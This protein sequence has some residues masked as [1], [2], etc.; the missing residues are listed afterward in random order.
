[1][2]Q[3]VTA[4]VLAASIVLSAVPVRPY[5]LQFTD[6]SGSARIK[7]PTNTINIA[8]ST[9]LAQPQA[10]IKRGSD[11]LGAVRRALAQW[12]EAANIKFIESSSP[13]KSISPAGGSGDGISLITVAQTPENLAPF[14]GA[15]SEMSGRTRVFFTLK[16]SITEADIVLNPTQQFSTD[17]TPGTYDLEAAFTHEIGHLLGLEH[18]GL[19]GSTMQPR[20]GKNGIYSLPAWTPRTL[21]EDDRAGVRALYGMRPGPARRGSI[22]GTISYNAG[23]PAFGA[24]VWAEEATTGRVSASNITLSNGA[25]R[26]DGL[27]PGNYRVMVEPLNGS[28]F[29]AEIA[30]ERGAYAGLTLNQ[31]VSFRTEEIGQVS[32]ASGGTVTLNAQLPPDAP[33]LNPSLVGLN[34][35]LSTISV[36]LNRGRTY[37]IYVGGEGINLNQIPN[38]G[39]TIASPF[40]IVNPTSVMQQQFG[41]GI[42]V[43]SFEVSVSPGAPLGD[44]SLRLQ[45]NTGEVAYLAGG[46]S[47]EGAER[48]TGPGESQTFGAPQ[49]A[50]DQEKEAVA[51]ESLAS[52]TGTLLFDVSIKAADAAEDAAL[53]RGLGSVIPIRRLRFSW[54]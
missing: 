6:A 51:Y 7:W 17:G 24:N 12:A 50:H 43:I 53:T 3:L 10:N 38:T 48:S 14:A 52:V 2:R 19:I 23:T 25:Y 4:F 39:I 49:P 33:S 28:V 5:T 13:V 41:T 44:Y 40:I 1:M 26:I 37:T 15:S 27:L 47:V 21:S 22:T 11:V 46:L 20:Q 29:A 16:G 9:S 54:G 45:S 42:S 32:V 35:Q 31:P 18:S 36:P 34:G 8:L 30:S